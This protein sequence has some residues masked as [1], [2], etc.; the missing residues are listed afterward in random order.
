MTRHAYPIYKGFLIGS[1]WVLV[2]V[3]MGLQCELFKN[4]IG[5]LFHCNLF[6]Y[7]FCQKIAHFVSCSLIK[8]TSMYTIQRIS[9]YV[10]HWSTYRIINIKGSSI[11]SSGSTT[12]QCNH[13]LYAWFEIAYHLTTLIIV[14][15]VEVAV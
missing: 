15:C 4:P 10:A 8:L 1:V 3:Y 11:E 6:I 5:A 7:L 9:T 12:Y 2:Q 14:C 13:L